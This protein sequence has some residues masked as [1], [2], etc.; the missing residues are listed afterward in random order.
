MLNQLGGVATVDAKDK[1]KVIHKKGCITCGQEYDQHES[2]CPD[3]GTI[4]TPLND[5]KLVGTILADRYEVLEVIGG[6]GMGLVYKARH[7][8]MNRIVAIKTL[9]R[10]LI[11]SAETLKRFQLEAQAASCL[12][13]PNILTIYDFGITNEGQPYMVMDYLEGISLSDILE[14]EGHLSCERFLNIFSQACA[15]LAHAHQKGV[16]HRDIKPSNIMLVNYGDQADFVKIVDFGIAKLLNQGD[17]SAGTLTRTGEVYGSPSFMSP[18]QCRGKELDMRSDIYSMGCVMYRSVTGS[19]PFNGQDI[20]ELLFKQVSEI[21]QSFEQVCPD[22]GL[23]EELEKIIFKAMAKDPSQR[24]QTMGD[25]KDAIDHLKDKLLNPKTAVD[26]VKPLWKRSGGPPEKPPSAPHAIP[27]AAQPHAE[28]IAVSSPDPAPLAAGEI[29]SRR[30]GPSLLDQIPTPST[31]PSVQRTTI[32][33]TGHAQSQPQPE[34][35][36]Q[37]ST[38][39]VRRSLS[40]T[41]NQQ[42]RVLIGII[43]AAVIAIFAGVWFAAKNT[44]EIPTADQNTGT[45]TETPPAKTAIVTAKSGSF[46]DCMKTALQALDRQDNNSAEANAAAAVDV[47]TK[48]GND[49][50]MGSSL[51]LLGR[52][53]LAQTNYAN[54]KKNLRDALIYR[55]KKYGRSSVETAE[56][57][58]YLGKALATTGD[59]SEAGTI[60]SEALSTQEKKLGAE[61]RT[62]AQTKIAI[63]DMDE[64]NKQVDKAQKEYQEALL[65][66]SKVSGKWDPAVANVE[67]ALAHIYERQKKYAEAEQLAKQA[68]AIKQELLGPTNPEVE[69]I[70]DLSAQI[71]QKLSPSDETSAGTTGTPATSPV[72]TTTKTVAQVA[73][74]TR[75]QPPERSH[76]ASH[77]SSHHGGG[78]HAV[79]RRRRAY[80]MYGF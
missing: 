54:A 80:S 19:N 29:T 17:G 49:A 71:A 6:G 20:I 24:Y 64:K 27:S 47:A 2:V 33:P 13:L 53:Y 58:T 26:G 61:N 28:G 70:K 4:L 79:V 73:P 67:L 48:S 44:Q 34:A 62:V 15:G 74:T 9:H 43:A 31:P 41:G 59:F 18:E 25:L 12:S 60:L 22:F 69:Q 30:N 42:P 56:T 45:A 7:R 23:P 36:A 21:P 55:E 3:D 57:L 68:L 16:L 39:A 11:S 65:I 66:L 76:H 8:L 5:D 40:R 35:R 32:P 50:Q 78:E 63:A 46:D 37:E 75:S 51:T 10:H 1:D 72:T 38:A 14:K 52:V 77:S